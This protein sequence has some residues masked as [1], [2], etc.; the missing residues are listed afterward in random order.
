MIVNKCYFS[1]S[2]P[3]ESTKLF[4][5]R[6]IKTIEELLPPNIKEKVQ[7]YTGTISSILVFIIDLIEKLIPLIKRAYEKALEF[8]ELILPYHPQLLVPSL[9]GI[10][11]CFFG[12]SFL[13]VIAAA[14]AYR[15]FNVII[16]FFWC[17][18]WLII[19]DNADI[20]QP[21]TIS[22]S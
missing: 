6:Q 17:N 8:W 1:P 15:F 4:V 3:T 11:L 10:I 19:S 14:E 16:Y 20:R 2:F 13:T 12:G 18:F 22:S 5:E 21:W 9:F 7:P